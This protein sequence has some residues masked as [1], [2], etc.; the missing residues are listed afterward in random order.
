MLERFQVAATGDHF[1][2]N[3]SPEQKAYLTQKGGHLDQLR[4][5]VP[6]TMKSKSDWKAFLMGDNPLTESVE[7][8]I[9]D[10]KDDGVIHFKCMLYEGVIFTR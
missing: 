7:D 9:R 3:L 8:A 10:C 2:D 4:D 6:N 1:T 5:D